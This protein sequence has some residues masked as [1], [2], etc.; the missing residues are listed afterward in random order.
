MGLCKSELGLGLL[1]LMFQ[2]LTQ[3][4]VN[5]YLVKANSLCD[6]ISLSSIPDNQALFVYL[7]SYRFV[8]FSRLLIV[9]IKTRG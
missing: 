6:A 8:P 1:F 5:Y 9:Q 4:E 7:R 3:T 2:M